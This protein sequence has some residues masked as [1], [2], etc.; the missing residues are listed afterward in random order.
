M[1]YYYEECSQNDTFK[2]IY[3]IIKSSIFYSII[4]MIFV[5][6]FIAYGCYLSFHSR[7]KAAEFGDSFTLLLTYAVEYIIFF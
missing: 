1:N 2:Y 5:A 3:F 6:L 7:H 4:I